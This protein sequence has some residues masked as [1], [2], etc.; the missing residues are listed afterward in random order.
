MLQP[1]DLVRVLRRRAP[2][3]SIR[4]VWSVTPLQTARHHGAREAADALAAVAAAPDGM[5][6]AAGAG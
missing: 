6:V 3:R 5:Y 4:E 1:R 2:T